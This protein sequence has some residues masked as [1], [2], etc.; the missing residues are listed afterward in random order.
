RARVRLRHGTFRVLLSRHD[1][2]PAAIPVA[3]LDGVRYGRGDAGA[4][5]ERSFREADGD[6]DDL[7]AGRCR[8]GLRVPGLDTFHA[9]MVEHGVPCIQEPKDVFGARLAQYL[10]PDGRAISVGEERRV[11]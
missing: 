5:P 3:R 8:P 9:R 1:R 2:S 10:D 11:V 7:P 6:P 4:P